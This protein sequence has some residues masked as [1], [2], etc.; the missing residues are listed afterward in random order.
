MTAIKTEQTEGS[1]MQVTTGEPPKR[2]REQRPVA[3]RRPA[4]QPPP[5]AK[6]RRTGRIRR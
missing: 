3:V 4:R 6:A 5:S 2:R 1:R